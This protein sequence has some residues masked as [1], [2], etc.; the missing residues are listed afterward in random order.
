MMGLLWHARN[1]SD[2][3]DLLLRKQ[4]AMGSGMTRALRRIADPNPSSGTISFAIVTQLV[5][6]LPDMQEVPGS[7][8]GD[9]TKFMRT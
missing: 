9:R 8:P 3:P 1:N 6:C 7:I 5:E 4:K 2:M